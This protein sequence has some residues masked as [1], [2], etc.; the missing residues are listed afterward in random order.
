MTFYAQIPDN[1]EMVIEEETDILLDPYDNSLL[2]E[3]QFRRTWMQVGKK[4]L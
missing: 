4:T 2:S 3:K 1:S